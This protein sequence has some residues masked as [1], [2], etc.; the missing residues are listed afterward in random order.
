[1]AYFGRSTYSSGSSSDSEDHEDETLKA[2]RVNYNLFILLYY[3]KANEFLLCY[4]LQNAQRAKELRGKFEAWEQSQDAKDQLA[5]MS[6]HDE[7]GE[8]L[9]TAGI[10]RRKFEALRVREEQAQ[11]RPPPI[12]A[13]FRPK[14]FKVHV[15]PKDVCNA[16]DSQMLQ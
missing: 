5:Q 8:P 9:E 15:L 12:K 3:V 14:R 4:I 2:I 13:Q 6:A 7:N 16:A 10:L 1:M 11:A